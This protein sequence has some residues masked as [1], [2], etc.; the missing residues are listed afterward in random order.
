MR[1]R[2]FFC[3]INGDAGFSRVNCETLL[4]DDVFLLFYEKT[5]KK[6]N[7]THKKIHTHWRIQYARTDIK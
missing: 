1:L 6:L 7:W 2:V 4:L 3:R 5:E